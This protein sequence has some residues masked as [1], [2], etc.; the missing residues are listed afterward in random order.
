VYSVAR[1]IAKQR[2]PAEWQ[3]STSGTVGTYVGEVQATDAA[4]AIKLAVQ[5]FDIAPEQR[6][7]IAARPIVV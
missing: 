7:R 1:R 3:I 5:K 6:D 4:A 2:Q